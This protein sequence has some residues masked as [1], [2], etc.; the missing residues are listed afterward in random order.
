MYFALRF[1]LAF[2]VFASALPAPASDPNYKYTCTNV[3]FDAATNILDFW[4]KISGGGQR[5]GWANIDKCIQN[6]GGVLMP[7]AG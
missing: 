4:C 5:H 6:A 3:G 2:A 7:G 1:L